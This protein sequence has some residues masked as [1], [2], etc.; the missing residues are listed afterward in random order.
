MRFIIDGVYLDDEL[1]TTTSQDLFDQIDMTY[2][3]LID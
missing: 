2:Q 1:D 3:D